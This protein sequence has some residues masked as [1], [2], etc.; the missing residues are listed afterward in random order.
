MFL[1]ILL[2]ILS[3]VLWVR[4]MASLFFWIIRTFS[5]VESRKQSVASI[6]LWFFLSLSRCLSFL[7]LQMCQL[8]LLEQG[9]WQ[10]FPSRCACIMLT[11]SR[12]MIVSEPVLGEYANTF[13]Q[14]YSLHVTSKW[15]LSFFFN[16]FECIW[17]LKRNNCSDHCNLQSLVWNQ[18]LHGYN[19]KFKDHVTGAVALELEL[20]QVSIQG[21]LNQCRQIQGFPQKF[22]L[23]QSNV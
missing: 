13:Q 17:V 23:L 20:Q 16:S 12:K 18:L 4:G 10:H 8:N 22:A 15:K 1:F 11:P 6:S 2:R 3:F 5:G 7:I 14:L 21:L 19:E 9:N